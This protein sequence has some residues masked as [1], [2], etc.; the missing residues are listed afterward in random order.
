MEPRR[1]PS[2][3]A[4]AYIAQGR[5]RH[6][7]GSE[8]R[9]GTLRQHE[10]VSPEA[11]VLVGI[12]GVVGE[13]RLQVRQ[14]RL[15]ASRCA[16]DPRRHASKRLARD[17]EAINASGRPALTLLL[18]TLLLVGEA[19]DVEYH[20]GVTGRPLL[21]LAIARQQAGERPFNDRRPGSGLGQP[22]PIGVNPTPDALPSN[23][24]PL[25]IYVATVVVTVLVA[26]I[27]LCRRRW[28][29]VTVPVADDRARVGVEVKVNPATTRP[30]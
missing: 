21:A 11:V 15:D 4:T 30:V 23:G 29:W 7:Q 10:P 20:L 24:I 8:S 5:R 12:D 19:P 1:K 25:V 14:Y 6:N 22:A 3:Q 28:S 17:C 2:I 27:V 16:S 18:C 9:A 13:R 26:I